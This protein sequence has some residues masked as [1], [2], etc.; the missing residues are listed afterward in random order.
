[1]TGDA[2]RTPAGSAGVTIHASAVLVGSRAVLICGPSGAGKSRLA[3]GLI[4]AARM[5][6]LPFAR[7]VADDRTAVEARHGR[8]LLRAPDTLAGLIE[9]R[10]VGIC[11]LPYE[12][13]AVAGLVIELDAADAARLPPPGW[14]NAAIEGVTL[15]RLVLASAVPLPATLIA[16][17]ILED[18][19][20][21]A[22]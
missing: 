10:G 21:R 14:S 3:L 8:L 6:R 12:P 13:V 11:R 2:L 9:V 16:L 7:L 18:S 22:S 1:V 17:Q 5:G 19:L 15:P 4:D 20:V